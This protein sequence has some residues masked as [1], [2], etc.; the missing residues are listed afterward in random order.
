MLLRMASLNGR[1]LGVMVVRGAPQ[2]THLFLADDSLIFGEA[3]VMRA[4]YL[5]IVLQLHAIFLGQLI[6]FA[7][8]S[9]FFQCECRWRQSIECRAHLE[10]TLCG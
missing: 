4:F 9:V 1:T 6:N 10:V 3:I 7:K 5:M 2:I 8:S